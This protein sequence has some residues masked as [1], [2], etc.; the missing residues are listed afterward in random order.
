[1]RVALGVEYAG[2]AFC[3][4]QSQP[5]HCGVQDALEDAIGEI[6]GHPVGVA[7]AGRTDAGVHAASQIVHFDT[8]AE[9]PTNAWVRGVNAHLPRTA[10][11]LWAHPVSPEF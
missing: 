10:A 6:A 9:R 11:V 4:F 2:G 5:S 3:G 7:A 8:D 1:M